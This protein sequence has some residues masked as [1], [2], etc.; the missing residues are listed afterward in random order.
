MFIDVGYDQ[1]LWNETKHYDFLLYP[2]PST[3]CQAMHEAAVSEGDVD[4]LSH[5][6]DESN[7]TETMQLAG[8]FS[9][10]TVMADVDGDENPGEDNDRMMDIDPKPM[11]YASA[12]LAVCRSS[13]PKLARVLALSR[14]G[15]IESDS[16]SVFNHLI[17]DDNLALAV[18]LL[19]Y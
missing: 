4:S 2:R 8:V 7:H 5:T 9:S 15:T 19:Q 14:R 13:E 12:L 17:V 16:H 11:V 6:V 1:G 10:T 18:K 3:L